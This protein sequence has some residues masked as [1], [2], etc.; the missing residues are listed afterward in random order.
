MKNLETL[1]SLIN[2]LRQAGDAECLL[3][4][5]ADEIERWSC[6][7][8]AA[9]A[10]QLARGLVAAGVQPGEFIPVLAHNR[11][12]W[13]VAML[14]IIGAGAAVSPLDSQITKEALERVLHDSEARFIFT[15]TE[16]LNRLG[17]LKANL[18][19]ILFDVEPDDER[20][21]QALRDNSDRPLPTVGLEDPAALFYTS[22]TTGVPKGVRLTHHNLLFQLKAIEAANLV[23]PTDRAL[24]PLPMYHVYPFTIGTLTPLTFRLPIILPHALT[25][26]QIIRALREGEVTIIIGVPRVYRAIY[27]GIEAQ[28]AGRGQVAAT[29]FNSALNTSN[30]LH[31]RLGWRV[32]QKLFNPLRAVAG[33]HLRLLTSGGSALAPDLAWKL[34]GLG[35]DIA[36][37]YGLTET[38]P[39]LTMNLPNSEVPR[40]GSVGRPL[41]GI[42]IRIDETVQAEGE[43]AAQ[44]NGRGPA[45]GEILARGPSVFTGYRNLPDETAQAFTDDGWFRTGDLG[46]FD[47]DGYLYIS[48]RASTLIV[49]EGGKKIQ[50]EPLEEIYQQHQFIREIGI[51][52]EA[53]QLVALIVPEMAEVNQYRNG[54]VEQAIR[55]AITE[56]SQAVASYQR[57]TDYA[58]TTEAIPRTNL[59][60]IRRHLLVKNYKLAKQGVQPE[61]HAVGPLPIADMSERD[62]A[63]LAQPGARRVWDWL[64][65]RYADKSLTPDTSPQLDLGIDSLEWLTL[66]LQVNNLTGVEL[67]DE[68]IRQISTVRDLL[69]AVQSAAE[70]E[71]LGSSSSL[72]E[73]MTMLT[74]EQKKWLR[75]LNRGQQ[76]AA[77]VLFVWL[78]GLARLLF[79]LEVHGLENLP[80][81][82]NFVLTPNHSSMLD[83]PMVAAAL[84]LEHLRRTTWIAAQDVM[85][86]NPL[87]R[88]VTRLAQVLPID[89]FTGGTGVKEMALAVASLRQ[90]NHLV[91]FPEGRLTPSDK[92]LPF[93]E[94]IGVVLEQAPVLVVPVYI[95][96]TRQ[97][98][99][100]ERA[101]PQPKPISITF[102]PP[103]EPNELAEQGEGE[104][105]S[106]RL[107]NALQQRVMALSE[108]PQHAQPR[109]L[110]K[111]MVIAPIALIGVAFTAI[112]GLIWWLV[113]GGGRRKS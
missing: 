26:P 62:Q 69:Q 105:A 85:L 76:R 40:L 103:C 18:R 39:M 20:S 35:W 19:P 51:L 72:P 113:K 87:M 101:L 73:A 11:P 60:K 3:A 64:A 37:G 63:L 14:A 89:R 16:Y 79:R 12:E 107:V 45:E 31:R 55:E 43:A 29:L 5:R 17:Q 83:A 90:D 93:R 54:D 28:I 92:M 65:S 52:Y 59:G 24:L 112:A 109:Q 78:K 36:I 102:G 91:W 110:T 67:S 84:P 66:T 99:P 42:E 27:D 58:T 49:L 111:G 33:P 22:G 96:G 4:F 50:P 98:M 81:D 2:D 82:R 100:P 70:K 46:Y 75:P 15:T 106:T 38:S 53:N 57:L 61:S 21:W 1:Q 86:T 25:G 6:A 47:A 94:G 41:T 95:Q 13:V 88:L 108:Q 68:A 30:G 44:R 8:V 80:R 56:R 74:D 23:H 97:A 71:S 77:T 10:E 9:A 32:G 34:E 7:D 104:L 48:G